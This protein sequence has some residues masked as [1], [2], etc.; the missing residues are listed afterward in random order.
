MGKAADLSDFDRGQIAMARRLGTSISETARLVVVRDLQLLVLMQR[1]NDG[2]SNSRRHGVGRP[3]AIKE[4]SRRRLSR[5]DS[6]LIINISRKYKIIV[7]KPAQAPKN[8]AH[9]LVLSF[10]GMTATLLLFFKQR[11]LTVEINFPHVLDSV[12]L[13]VRVQYNF[14]VVMYK[15]GRTKVV[16][17]YYQLLI[18]RIAGILPLTF[19]TKS[20]KT[21]VRN[22]LVT[23]CS[24]ACGSFTGGLLM[25]T[26]GAT[27]AFQVIGAANGV[28]FL[29]YSTYQYLRRS[30]KLRR[31]D[32]S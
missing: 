22:P 7:C 23:A 27:T 4:K 18:A 11:V 17:V 1:G 19:Y 3:H 31:F 10:H 8:C 5:M 13:S 12:P 32:V 21:I 30:Q 15:I 2:E 16:R 6:R 28:A 14:G 29:L 24:R 9:S 20:D 26:Y 25:S